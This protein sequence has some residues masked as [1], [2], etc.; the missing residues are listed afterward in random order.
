MIV[1]RSQVFDRQ[2]AEWER[3]QPGSEMLTRVE[4]LSESLSTIAFP[5]EVRLIFDSVGGCWRRAEQ[6]ARILAK[7]VT[8]SGIPAICLLKLLAQDSN[9]YR[10][11]IR[12]ARGYGRTVL[13]PLAYD[14]CAIAETTIDTK[15]GA[16]DADISAVADELADSLYAWLEPPR[17]DDFARGVTYVVHESGE[18]VRRF[19][20]RAYQNYA[21]T[22]R[23]LLLDI[24]SR[25]HADREHLDIGTL[26]SDPASD[27]HILYDV[28][29]PT[30]GHERTVLFLIAPVVG[31][32]N[33]SEL[34]SLG[35]VES[36][37]FR[38]HN[39]PRGRAVSADEIAS[40]S[41]RAYPD[42]LVTDSRAWMSIQRED[43]GNLALSAEEER[44]LR[45][46]SSGVSGSA[47]P[48]F[49]NGRAGSGKSTILTYLFAD[50]CH[51]KW[52]RGLPGLPLFLT[53]NHRLLESVKEATAVILRTHH[54]FLAEGD[55]DI[56]RAEFDRCFSTFRELI[57]TS[58]PDEVRTRY[59]EDRRVRF[60]D[61]KALVMG[62]SSNAFGDRRQRLLQTS[63][64]MPGPY[65]GP[66]RWSPEM[67]WQVIRTYIKGA[68]TRGY[69]TPEAYDSDIPR[70]ERLVSIADFR[71]IYETV[72]LTWYRQ[73]VDEGDF[74]DDQDLA[75]EGIVSG[76][77]SDEY[78]A[79]LCDES[80]DFTSV[81]LRLLLS[82]SA[83]GRCD[84]S[85]RG[86]TC[87]P[88]AF[89][90]DPFQ[91]LN[92]T[93]FRWSS[94]RAA[95]YREMI[96]VMDPTGQ[97]G[98]EMGFHDLARNYRS[99]APIVRF[100]NLIQ[101]WRRW[102]FDLVE[103]SPQSAWRPQHSLD[104]LKYI[105]GK[106]LAG[107]VF[108]GLVKNTIIIVP[109]DEGEER[110]FVAN[111]PELRQLLVVGDTDAPV[112]NVLSAAGAKGLEF[113]RVVLYKFGEHCDPGI[114]GMEP[115]EHG[116]S[117]GH[118]YFL[119]KLYVAASRA[120]NQLFIVDSIAG[121]QALWL[122]LHDDVSLKAL[123]AQPDL[124]SW[125]GSIGQL[126]DGTPQSATEMEEDDLGAI[127][128]EFK[129]KGMATGNTDLLRRAK[130]YYWIV[131]DAFE[132]DLCEAGA[133]RAERRFREAADLYRRRL[134]DEEAVKCL[135]RGNCWPEL[136]EW[137]G[138]IEGQWPRE[139]AVARFMSA[140][141]RDT[142]ALMEF[143]GF[144]ERM[145]PELSRE[146]LLSEQWTLAVQELRKR[147][148]RL[149]G[150]ARGVGWARIGSQL[151]LATEMGVRELLGGAAECYLEASEFHSSV[152][153]WERYG[154]VDGQDYFIAKA[155]SIG[156]PMNLTWWSRASKYEELIEEW[157]RSG[158]FAQQLSDSTYLIVAE[159]LE[160]S[161]N[162]LSGVVARVER[163]A[164]GGRVRIEKPH[165]VVE[166]VVAWS[167]AGV[168]ERSRSL[169]RVLI[170]FEY[171]LGISAY[172]A[173]VAIL[174]RRDRWGDR[175]EALDILESEVSRARTVELDQGSMI[176]MEMVDRGS[177]L[178]ILEVD[179]PRVFALLRAVAQDPNVRTSFSPDDLGATIEKIGDES[180]AI[181]F[182]WRMRN[183]R[184]TRIRSHVRERWVDLQNKHVMRLEASGN[185]RDARVLDATI[186]RQLNEWSNDS[187]GK[188]ANPN[189]P[190]N[191]K[192]ARDGQ[193]E[194]RT[195]SGAK[196]TVEEIS[197]LGGLEIRINRE[198]RIVSISD[199]E[200]NVV[201][202]D[203]ASRVLGGINVTLAPTNSGE[204]FI[205][206]DSS[207]SGT[208]TYGADDARVEVRIQGGKAVA[209]SV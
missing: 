74:W 106:S 88:F 164:R 153:C 177:R 17:W 34:H 133:L 146:A 201:K 132:A 109:C 137:Y 31:A 83:L 188:S 56:P 190:S 96:D 4:A 208:V 142:V 168:Y 154:Q 207:W 116:D 63:T 15:H 41:A 18:W 124:A 203:I 120:L 118:Q 104:P 11:F 5:Q 194:R 73:W 111:D 158:G 78:V 125:Q 6:S 92:P 75:R 94:L 3:K 38:G 183:D 138:M 13:D 122:R 172:Q 99:S 10:T 64:V 89:A 67:A 26:A 200:Y 39:A 130:Q 81:E 141:P 131:G 107:E 180:G 87:L 182:Y 206:G 175:I 59:V 62:E 61:F 82:V 28:L 117:L 9:D 108:R 8:V 114:W 192:S 193:S 112:R 19:R 163:G 171:E 184:V 187:N 189:K 113:N 14:C 196:T 147:A 101:L 126:A 181:D 98:M 54:R 167:T 35:L 49:I 16:I 86:I 135:W 155:R 127:A 199:A 103:L 159:A 186:G 136:L 169:L 22:F 29:S 100:S 30:S 70:K 57:L 93:G 42:Y 52:R 148:V 209:F 191:V 66:R 68:S 21:D 32:I 198:K 71:E 128:D 129:T 47:M 2:L 157:T 85:R 110:R 178:N 58:L 179:R 202:I 33:V 160:R 69:L 166:A 90:G 53:Y 77:F 79:L 162:D 44:I 36:P 25:P 97:S 195:R 76:R 37:R 121:D 123:L 60:Q 119:N 139:V 143:V 24:S 80:Q 102:L 149:R 20:Q 65:H 204:S 176:V 45:D 185:E 161:V 150:V 43:S 134:R 1:L 151:E 170:R 152:R 50:Y 174:R 27:C 95:F 48:L 140:G 55:V 51:R 144:L 40:L 105:I 197:R 145:L 72:W 115:E 156:Y 91:T 23:R 12:D 165:R 7:V 173:H 84:W 46:A 205:V